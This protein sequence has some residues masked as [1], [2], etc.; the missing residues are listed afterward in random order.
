MTAADERFRGAL[1][2]LSFFGEK[3]RTPLLTFLDP[4]GFPF[5]VR[6]VAE[7]IEDS[8]C[9]ITVTAAV[10][11]P[12]GSTPASLLWH[13][14]NEVLEDLGSLLL[15]GQLTVT[16]EGASFRATHKPTSS[17]IGSPDWAEMFASFERNAES[18]LRDYGQTPPEIDWPA[19]E[20]L[21]AEV[22]GIDR[23]KGRP[24]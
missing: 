19:F 8:T 9:Q 18:Y 24:G 17:G 1:D 15:R 23:G 11:Q 7:W 2:D 12:S 14:H 21:V 16:D 3:A 22:R 5:S 13:T 20:R 10:P 6:V 4:D